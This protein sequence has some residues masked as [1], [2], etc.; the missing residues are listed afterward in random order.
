MSDSGSTQ[1]VARSASAPTEPGLREALFRTIGPGMLPGVPIRDWWRMLCD[2]RFRV[3]L[4]AAPKLLL[5]TLAAPVTSI[6]EWFERRNYDEEIARQKVVAPIFVLGHWRSGTTHLHNLLSL[7]GRFAFP[8]FFDAMLPHTFLTAGPFL[9]NTFGRLLPATRFGLDNVPFHAR[10]PFEEDF[11]LAVGAMRSPYMSWIFPERSAY[12]DR[13]VT[14]EDVPPEDVAAFKAA[15]LRFTQKLTLRYGRRLVLKS[16]PQTGRVRLLLE[17][18]PDARFVHIHRNP[19]EVYESTRRM[20]R[21]CRTYFSFQGV[22]YDDRERVLSLYE[23]MYSAFFRDVPTIPAGQFFEMP[24]ESLQR[25][26][27]VRLAEMY[28]ALGLPDFEVARPAMAEYVA[29]QAEYKKR[30]YPPL[31]D[32][33]R[34]PIVERWRSTFEKWGYPI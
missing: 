1:S 7:D 16:P 6:V 32:E 26:P 8:N 28:E 23:Q 22:D 29:G 14:L 4:R 25:E 15:L 27:M 10:A 18:F 5:T 3:R 17:L 9:A 20:H 31:P 13:F 19:Y 21:I 33:V 30:H 11:T 24:F 2:N 34:L 12:Y